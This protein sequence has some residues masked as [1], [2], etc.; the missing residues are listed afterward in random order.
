MITI[1]EGSNFES[2][3]IRKLLETKGLTVFVNYDYLTHNQPWTISLEE[4]YT[5]VLKVNP[6]DQMKAEALIKKY[7]NRVLTKKEA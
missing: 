2:I 3:A 5:T 4:N 6:A 7:Y 1:Y